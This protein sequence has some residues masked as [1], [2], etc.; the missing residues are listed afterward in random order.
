MMS[1]KACSKHVEAYYYYYYYY[2]Y[3]ALGLV[4]AGT[5]ALSGDRDGFGTLHPGQVLTGSLPLLSP[6][7]LIIEIN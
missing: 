5:R 4:W 7:R 2:Y 3:S 1:R 6:E